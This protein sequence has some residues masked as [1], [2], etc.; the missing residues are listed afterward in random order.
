MKNFIRDKIRKQLLKES[1]DN[2]LYH[3]GE[4][5]ITKL[6][7]SKIAGGAR[8]VYGWGIY[9]TDSIHKAN[10]YGGVLTLMDKSKL[11][12]LDTRQVVNQDFINKI[13]QLERSESDSMLSAFYGVIA[14]K[15]KEQ[16]GKTIDDA[17]KNISD[18]FRWDISQRWSEM[19]KELEFDAMKNGYEYVIINF[20]AGNNA[21]IN[22]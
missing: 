5:K 4:A 11:K 8:G 6:D 7:P 18:S 10:D 19:I 22:A 21:L 12:I 1:N 9:F 15:L 14:S 17:R 13:L 2:I 16:L 20:D 3:A